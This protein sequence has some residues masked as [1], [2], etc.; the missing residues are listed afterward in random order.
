MRFICHFWLQPLG[1][2]TT[3]QIKDS[4]RLIWDHVLKHPPPSRLSWWQPPPGPML[5]IAI[6]WYQNDQS[7]ASK[8]PEP[9]KAANWVCNDHISKMLSP[10]KL[11]E[12]VPDVLFCHFAHFCQGNASIFC[13]TKPC[14]GASNTQNRPKSPPIPRALP[15]WNHH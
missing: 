12:N 13:R 1:T 8:G 14:R 4:G 9:S 7:S 2:P 6:F 15:C 5:N 11:T 3:S 10:D